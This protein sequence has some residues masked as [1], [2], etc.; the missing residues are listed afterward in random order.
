[1]DAGSIHRLLLPRRVRW[2]PPPP[3]RYPDASAPLVE[4]RKQ[5]VEVIV[6]RSTSNL[7]GL[8]LLNKETGT[9]QETTDF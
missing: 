3:N 5:Q 1:M 9:P 4:D 7:D 2:S 8:T 6:L